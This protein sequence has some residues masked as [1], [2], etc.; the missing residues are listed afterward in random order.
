MHGEGRLR[1]VR[2]L[3]QMNRAELIE[4]VT[5]ILS[6]RPHLAELLPPE[7]RALVD[8]S[9][10]APA[11]ARPAAPPPA[12]EPPRVEP[13]PARPAPRPST[14]ASDEPRPVDDASE[15]VPEAPE[16]S[17]EEQAAARAFAGHVQPRSAGWPWG[18]RPPGQRYLRP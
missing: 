3:S 10:P 13:D 5:S 8:P 15:P 12:P 16:P 11:P 9:P 7:L 2:Y 14:P 18:E 6:E 1:P 4:R 17:D